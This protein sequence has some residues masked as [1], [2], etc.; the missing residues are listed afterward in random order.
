MALLRRSLPVVGL[1]PAHV[2]PSPTPAFAKPIHAP[3]P[4]DKIIGV[5]VL[6]NSL[7]L[8]YTD[9]AKSNVPVLIFI[10]GFPFDHTMWAAQAAVADPFFRVIT[11]D[12]RGHGRSDAGDGQYAFEFFV[13]DLFGLMDALGIKQAI[14]CGLSMGGYTALR[15]TE[16]D[17]ERVQGL[18]LCD[19]QSAPD[20]NEAKLKR[21]ASVRTIQQGGIA[22]FT[23]GFL[24]A[25]FSPS[26][27][28]QKIKIVDQIRRVILANPLKGICGTLI[29]LATRTDTT[30]ALANIR[31][32]TLILVGDQDGITPPAA[33]QAMHERIPGS[34]MAVI[35][36]A[37][38]LSTVENP[39]AFNTPFREF[40]KTLK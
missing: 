12:H 8:Y 20:S 37:G 6:V 24:K 2:C 26:S 27:G 33:A 3:D 1:L 22:T 18:I 4:H 32:P 15:A 29:A 17:P 25:I 39:E 5:E 11:Y 16:R 21:A 14:L 10:H 28:S 31:V 9:N 23:E 35:P 7:K 34:Q 19:T 13:D 40:I 36:N 38:H 30:P